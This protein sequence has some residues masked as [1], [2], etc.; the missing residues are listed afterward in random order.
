MPTPLFLPRLEA[1]HLA[2]INR[3]SSRNGVFSLGLGL[4]RWH[5]QF[6]LRPDPG[7]WLGVTARVGA[8]S[9]WLGFSSVWANRLLGA[10][11][12]E[13]PDP[14]LDPE[15]RP[16]FLEM[17][18]AGWLDAREIFLGERIE[19]TGIQPAPAPPP[20]GMA[21]P[22]EWLPEDGG[23][24]APGLLICPN[25]DL[26]GQLADWLERL[27]P[28]PLLTW[29]GII[30]FDLGLRLGDTLLTLADLKSIAPGDIIRIEHALD[31]TGE[32]ALLTLHDLAWPVY[33]KPDATL[34]ILELPMKPSPS[35]ATSAV[36][37][38][39]EDL[40]VNLVFEVGEKTLA[41]AEL[42][43]LQPGYCFA[44]DK[45]P[46]DQAVT[47]RANGRAVGQGELVD[48]DGHLGVRILAWVGHHA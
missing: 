18:L 33:L 45:K 12:D 40:P 24:P 27:P 43:R 13:A 8:G 36:V 28:A 34:E 47:I 39:L 22:L 14:S 29:C 42:Q 48:L 37:A 20:P 44:L 38:S 3:A 32:R 6:P 7:E 46:L 10:W 17:A 41:L 4:Q 21:L 26:A 25:Q 35:P 15:I 31:Q 11:F 2:L 30:P 16:L 23:L 9:L 1:S 5:L 19:I